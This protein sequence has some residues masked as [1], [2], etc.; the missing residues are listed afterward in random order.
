MGDIALGPSVYRWL[1]LDTDRPQL[2]KLQARHTR[3]EERPTY[4]RTVMVPFTKENP[5]RPEE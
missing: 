4:R 5:A 2:S 3:P 1:N